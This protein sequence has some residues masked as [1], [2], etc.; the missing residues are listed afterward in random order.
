MK[1][2]QNIIDILA[3]S[4]SYTMRKDVRSK[5]DSTNNMMHY[6]FWGNN[7]HHT[8]NVIFSSFLKKEKRSQDNRETK[9]RGRSNLPFKK[10]I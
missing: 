10:T 2:E 5:G 8:N 7:N 6:R 3:L 4:L 1:H 9:T